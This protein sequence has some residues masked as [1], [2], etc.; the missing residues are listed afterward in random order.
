MLVTEIETIALAAGMSFK[1]GNPAEI[2]LILDSVQSGEYPVLIYFVPTVVNDTIEL[3]DLVRSSF[4]FN[5]AVLDRISA[6]TIDYKS[7]EVQTIIDSSRTLARQ[8]VKRLNSAEFIDTQTAGIETVNYPS[9][10]AEHDAHLF[11]VA[12]ECDIPVVTGSTFC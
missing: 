6:D 8:F 5:G 10:Y 2:N 4:P 1:Y 3:N 12:I 7:E 11:G 9:L